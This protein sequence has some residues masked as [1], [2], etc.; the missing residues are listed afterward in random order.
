MEQMQQNGGKSNN[1]DYRI[2]CEQTNQDR[3][4]RSTFQPRFSRGGWVDGEKES[5]RKKKETR[6]P[7]YKMA[8]DQE[9]GTK[10]PCLFRILSA[11]SDSAAPRP[12]SAAA[13]HCA[14]NTTYDTAHP[15]YRVFPEPQ[16]K[17][18]D[19]EISFSAELGSLPPIPQSPEPPAI[20]DTSFS[21]SSPVEGV[22]LQKKEV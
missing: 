18:N 4:A 15:E 10:T 9:G 1:E 11:Y 7:V 13:P 22:S 8:S 17:D 2:F 12:H 6:V 3:N 21:P 20:R 5:P 14:Y 16:W 19:Y